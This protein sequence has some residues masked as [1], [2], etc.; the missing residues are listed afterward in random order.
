[1][2]KVT[3]ASL[4][5]MGAALFAS[6][7]SCARPGATGS[8]PEGGVAGG[9]SGGSGSGDLPP[10][11]DGGGGIDLSHSPPTTGTT[12]CMLTTPACMSMCADFP[13]SPVIDLHPD[14]GSAPTPMD[15]PS[16]FADPGSMSGGPCLVEPTDKTLIPQNWLRPR[17]RY[18]PAAGQNLF[19]IRLHADSETNDYLVYTTSKTWK[20]PNGHKAGTAGDWDTI[21]ASIWGQDIT[22]TVRGVN[23]SDP[24]S[25]PAG[26]TAKFRIAPAGA[27]GAMIYWAAA[28]D[29]P[30]D[31]WLEGFNVGDEHVATVLTPAQVQLQISRDQGGQLQT[32]TPP[33]GSV[34]CIG[35]HAAIPDGVDGGVG[36]SVA[37]V[38]FYPWTGVVS[39]VESDAGGVVPAWLTGGGGQAF[40]QPWIGLPTFSK[41]DWATGEHIAI[42]SY[43]CPPGTSTSGGSWY[44]WNGSGCS[45]QPSAGLAWFDLSSSATAI[46]STNSYD[47]GM[48]VGK[49]QGTSWGILQRTGDTRGAEFAN[50]SHD[51]RTIVYVSTNAGKDGRLATGTADLY[52]V[53]YN[54][55]QGGAAAPVMGASDATWAEFYPSYSPNDSFIAYN[56]APGAE[57][58]YYNPHDEVFIIPSDGGM[59]T[60]LDAND[61]PACLG[62]KVPGVT[63]SWPKWSPSVQ[64][65][66]D[67]V[68]YYW[69]IFS[70][71]RDGST[72]NPAY[73][74][75]GLSAP[76]PTSQLYLTAVTVDKD[77]NLQTYPA[78][79]V[80]NQP[81]TS[82]AFAGS[83]QSN[84]TPVWEEV[85]IPPPPPPD[86]SQ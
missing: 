58:M 74:K 20:M 43:G 59:A 12:P 36:K 63:N 72:F 24:S 34:Q 40:S 62:L 22:V 54:A 19:E 85:A 33:A 86:K 50:W 4:A 9:G 60:R 10:E 15:A 83:N 41:T 30:G 66:S 16:H 47:V 71:S 76:L 75:M 7:F 68:T 77:K 18:V 79:Y 21:R 70:S 57:N 29:K 32:M 49:D 52:T 67:G 61:P 56:R 65:C 37:F 64:Q 25:K 73:F 5:V 11:G 2:V 14:D 31:S 3:L 8:E 1:M 17:F 53:A 39:E 44:P 82:A 27:G 13:T 51:G 35:C 38:D 46:A 69:I 26:T 28:G 6:A 42:A 55:R 78:L 81:A 45:D 80:W 23:M 48:G 84:H